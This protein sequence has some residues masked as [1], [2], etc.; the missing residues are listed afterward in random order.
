MQQSNKKMKK[1]ILSI[2]LLLFCTYI[3]S[4]EFENIRVHLSHP[5][6]MQSNSIETFTLSINNRGDA[7]LHSLELSVTCNDDL[8]VVLSRQKI[9]FL[10]PG[11]TVRIT[12]E[13]SNSHS[14]FFDRNNLVA[15]NITNEDYAGNFS[16]RIT[17]RAIE[18]FW[19]LVI[20]SLAALMIVLFII[21]YIKTNKGEKNA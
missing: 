21:V 10:E 2:I 11:E 19:F 14:H 9:D 8:L 6:Y 15:F 17:I 4:M 7:A 20:L 3:F 1:Y 18:N 13:I 12:V 16:F 5:R